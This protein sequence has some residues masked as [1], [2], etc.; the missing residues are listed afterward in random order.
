MRP[1][2]RSETFPKKA[3]DIASPARAGIDVVTA[4]I[5]IDNAIPSTIGSLREKV[6][7]PARR[8]LSCDVGPAES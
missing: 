7:E 4:N 2:K 3:S 8:Q 1:T 5:V 6:R